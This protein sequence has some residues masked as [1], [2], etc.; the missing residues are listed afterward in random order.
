LVRQSLE[1]TA[2]CRRNSHPAAAFSGSRD[3]RQYQMPPGLQIG[4]TKVMH[5]ALARALL[6]SLLVMHC[7]RTTI[8]NSQDLWQLLS[9]K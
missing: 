3:D 8:E 4:S 1:V 5:I 6:P 2:F 9:M 7:A